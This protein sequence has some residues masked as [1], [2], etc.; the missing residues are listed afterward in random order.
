MQTWSTTWLAWSSQLEATN[1]T[2]CQKWDHKGEN[3]KKWRSTTRNGETHYCATG[4]LWFQES[5]RMAK[6][7]TALRAISHIDQTQREGR[8]P[9]DQHYDLLHRRWNRRYIV[10]S[11][12]F[13][14][15]DEKKYATV[16][17]K[18]SQHFIDH[19]EKRDFWTCKIQHEKTRTQ[20]ASRGVHN[21]PVSLFWALWI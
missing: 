18:L 20:W 7:D 9:A 8:S 12:T 16:K 3:D 2:W 14:T 11:F 10:T 4:S 17:E 5:R 6:M 19:Q 1:R 13:A 21:R 15:G